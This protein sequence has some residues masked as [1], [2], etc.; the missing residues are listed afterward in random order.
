MKAI[1]S[2][3]TVD[4]VTLRYKMSGLDL[5][6]DLLEIRN[7]IPALQG[8]ARMILK[9]TMKHCDE[10]F[11]SRLNE[12]IDDSVKISDTF[13]MLIEWL[14]LYEGLDFSLTI[15]LDHEGKLSFDYSRAIF[16]LD[17]VKLLS[18]YRKV[19]LYFNQWDDEA[20]D[21]QTTENSIN[22]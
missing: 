18:L 20:R 5:S 3:N 11:S 2:I 15:D 10:D 12:L 22:L 8:L 9:G 14:Q 17:F 4:A 6:I 13:N 16:S 21:H 7:D 19:Y 1:I